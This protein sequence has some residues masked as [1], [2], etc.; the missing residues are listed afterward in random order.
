MFT[1]GKFILLPKL[2]SSSSLLVTGTAVANS[3]NCVP[4]NNSKTIRLPSV[5]KDLSDYRSIYT[6]RFI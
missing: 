5:T 2:F 6:D 3:Y 4:I 1:F